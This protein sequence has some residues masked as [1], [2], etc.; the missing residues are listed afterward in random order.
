MDFRGLGSEVRGSQ[1]GVMVS[2]C[3]SPAGCCLMTRGC[4]SGSPL[5]CLQLYQVPLRCLKTQA[6]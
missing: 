2:H 3:V 1:E 5:I 4:P 6:C